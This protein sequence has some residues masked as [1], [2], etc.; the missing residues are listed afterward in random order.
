MGWQDAPIVTDTPQQPAGVSAPAPSNQPAWMSAPVVDQPKQQ[1]T[2]ADFE[3]LIRSTSEKY[4]LDPRLTRAVIATESNFNPNATSKVGAGGLMQLMPST[5]SEL[6][7]KNVYDPAQNVDGGVRYLKKMLDSTGGNLREAL[8]AYNGGIGRLKTNGFDKMPQESKDYVLKVLSKAG[9]EDVPY[10]NGIVDTQP[11]QQAPQRGQDSAMNTVARTL[12]GANQGFAH[13]IPDAV[14]QLIGAALPDSV[15]R[16]MDVNGQTLQESVAAKE[17]AY[18]DERARLG[19]EGV[20]LGRLAGNIA[21]P[22]NLALGAAGAP[23]WVAKLGPKGQALVSSMLRGGIGAGL[24]P[25]DTTKGGTVLGGKA[26]QV[27]LGTALGPVAEAVGRGVGAGVGRVAGAIGGK[28]NPQAQGAIDLANANGVKL[29]AGDINPENKMVTGIEGALENSRIPGLSMSNFRKQQQVGAEAAATKLRDE[30]FTKLQAMSYSGIDRLR[31]L[32]ASNG[33][34]SPEARKILDMVD[35][36]GTDERAI[37][38]ASGNLG[39]LQRKISAD[40][41]Y[42]DVAEKAGDMHVAPTSTIKAIDDAIKDASDVVDIDPK[43]I[44]DLQR[45]RNNLTRGDGVN[46]DEDPIEAAVR[47]FEGTPADAA[48]VPNTYARMRAFRS[49]LRSRLDQA[50]TN[51]TTD[52]SKL[53]MKNIATA[54]EQDMDDFAQ[55]TP[56]L[57]EANQRAQEFYKR[58]VVPYQKGKLASALTSDNPDQIYGSF[59]RAQAEGRGDYAAQELFRALDN[60]GRQAVRYGI[61]RQAMANSVDQGRFS[62]AK[63][64]SSLEGTEYRQYFRDPDGRARVDG[65]VNLMGLLRN[66]SPEHLEKYAPM[67]GG[68][69]GLGSVGLGAMAI[70][71]GKMAAGLGTAG[72][73]RWLMT[74]DAGKRVL[75]STNIFAKG[76]SKEQI[77][78]HLDSVFRQFS[79]AAGTATGAEVGKPGTV[80]P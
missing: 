75:N 28:I 57:A 34:R 76:G 8:A 61:V 51:G 37:M 58:H 16:F 24:Q 39:W 80:V 41:L 30:E 4:G 46:L 22:P 69:L 59:I 45:W 42:T 54:V 56:G 53:F 35:N 2:G 79:N 47:Q 27:A 36:A 31:S 52:S 49:D 23:A 33:T 43:A 3:D 20:D 1:Q 67:L 29:S 77:G 55:H 73:L 5:A 13:D 12:M 18:Q 6:G 72:F 25:V 9:D 66:A 17:K 60:K 26:E 7:V 15:Q 65:L 38:Q 71:P 48:T 50:T 63:F 19:G 64:R 70:G 21:S 62:P 11:G 68:T 40:K 10:T 78:A 44:S 32:A 74:S 14:T